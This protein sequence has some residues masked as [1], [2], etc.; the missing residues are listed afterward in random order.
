MGAIG[1][2]A[3][4]TG[5]GVIGSGDAVAESTCGGAGV[6]GGCGATGDMNGIGV[7]ERG[8]PRTVAC[9]PPGAVAPGRG[10]GPPGRG[11]EGVA[12]G[13]PGGLSGES[14]G[15]VGGGRGGSGGGG[16]GCEGVPPTSV[17]TR[18]AGGVGVGPSGPSGPGGGRGGTVSA[19]GQSL[20]ARSGFSFFSGPFPSFRS[21]TPRIL[22]PMAGLNRPMESRARS[23]GRHGVAARSLSELPIFGSW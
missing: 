14:R 22:H 9:D 3:A 21:G 23:R 16:C 1:A 19:L 4:T 11:N 8:M 2:G 7:A 13:F 6:A 12:I 17:L 10:G 18:R 5:A 15:A 20:S